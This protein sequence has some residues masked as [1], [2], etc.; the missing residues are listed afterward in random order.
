ML[1]YQYLDVHFEVIFSEWFTKWSDW[2][3]YPNNA[4]A[5]GDE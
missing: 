2:I 4:V 5:T 1:L 3:S